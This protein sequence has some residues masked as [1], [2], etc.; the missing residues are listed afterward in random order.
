MDVFEFTDDD[1]DDDLAFLS[2]AGQ[3]ARRLSGGERKQ[4]VAKLHADT[5]SLLQSLQQTPSRG[6]YTPSKDR[7]KGAKTDSPGSRTQTPSKRRKDAALSTTPTP[8]KKARTVV[9]T[10]SSHRTKQPSR[11]PSDVASGQP[12]SELPLYA[13]A[14]APKTATMLVQLEDPTMDLSGDT[15]AIGRFQT[16]GDSAVM[17]DIKGHQ[18]IGE[19]VPCTSFMVVGVCP[20][21]ARV[22]CVMNE[23][24]QITHKKDLL[25]AL[26]GV[27]TAGCLDSETEGDG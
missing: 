13:P 12:S 19:I 26:D 20:T 4:E 25:T 21:E 14:S 10:A 24:C 23:F 27:V 16:Q 17:L 3:P 8:L 22:E 2:G 15:G 5:K 7:S 11:H 1:S 6:R 18:Y 9:S